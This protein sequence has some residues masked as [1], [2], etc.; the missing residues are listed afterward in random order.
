LTLSRSCGLGL[1]LS[2]LAFGGCGSTQTGAGGS[3]GDF[4]GSSGSSGSSGAGASSGAGGSGTGG[5]GAG[6]GSRSSGANSG[7]GG[8]GANS[9]SGGS[10]ANSGSGGSGASSGSGSSGASSGSGAGAG[11]SSGHG[12][13]GGGADGAAGATNIT[14]MLGSAQ[15]KPI[16]SAFLV[17]T[18]PGETII[19][20]IAGP[21]TCAQISIS[22]WLPSIAAGTQVI[23]LIVPSTTTTGMVSIP[24][25]EANYAFGGMS[26]LTETVATS[27]S[28]NITKNTPNTAIEG[29]VTAT[30]ASGSIMGSFHADYC[31]GGMGF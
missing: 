23:E 12:D 25:G 5:S 13:A 22:G 14:G 9:G 27:G 20:L 3:S 8:S 21:V 7:S 31:A 26:S 18:S 1:V 15:V 17:T 11:A 4:G 16:V 19:Y 29:T 24:S 6:S 28:I 2:L 30:Y 10:G